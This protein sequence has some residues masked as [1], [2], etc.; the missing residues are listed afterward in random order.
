MSRAIPP[1]AIRFR[2]RLC[3][4]SVLEPRSLVP[5]DPK[6]R[7]GPLNMIQF[8]S[9]SFPDVTYSKCLLI[10]LIVQA[11]H[12][13][14]APVRGRSSDKYSQT[15]TKAVTNA[16]TAFRHI[17]NSCTW[18]TILLVANE[19]AG[20][21]QLCGLVYIGRGLWQGVRTNLNRTV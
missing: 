7:T 16:N 6:I 18:Q 10:S 4:A 1:V 21:V 8:L 19:D 17:C 14:T 3:T 9:A 5:L 20:K 12:R 13:S 2:C 15:G 11:T